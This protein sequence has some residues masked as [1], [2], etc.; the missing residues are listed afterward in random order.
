MKQNLLNLLVDF[1]NALGVFIQSE[2]NSTEGLISAASSNVKEEET[3]SIELFPKET[4]IKPFKMRRHKTGPSSAGLVSLTKLREYYGLKGSRTVH[5][6]LKEAGIPFDTSWKSATI[7]DD[8]NY[9]QEIY[10]DK[11]HIAIMNYKSTIND[12]TK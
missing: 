10:L 8:K 7:P 9:V 4:Q 11:V 1:Y 3:P 5:K 12:S 6:I 2:L